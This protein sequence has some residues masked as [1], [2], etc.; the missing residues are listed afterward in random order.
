MEKYL[1]L[2]INDERI[3]NDDLLIDL[4]EI[5]QGSRSKYNYQYLNEIKL[6]TFYKNKE[7]LSRNLKRLEEDIEENIQSIRMVQLD[8]HSPKINGR[9]FSESKV[10]KNIAIVVCLK[11]TIY[12]YNEIVFFCDIERKDDNYNIQ[13][14]FKINR[15]EFLNQNKNTNWESEKQNNVNLKLSNDRQ[16][17]LTKIPDIKILI[18]EAEAVFEKDDY[19]EDKLQI[20]KWF[21][22]IKIMSKIYENDGDKRINQIVIFSKKKYLLS[23]YE[24]RKSKSDVL[25]IT[26]QGETIKIHQIKNL[27]SVK[28]NDIINKI[29]KENDEKISKLKE[30][31]ENLKNTINSYKKI[32]IEDENK[33]KE[34]NLE[35][36]SLEDHLSQIQSDLDLFKLKNSKDK[37][38]S[39]ELENNITKL[40]AEIKEQNSL[41]QDLKSKIQDLL[42]VIDNNKSKIKKSDNDAN[43][44]KKII[45]KIEKKQEHISHFKN[46]I[47][48]NEYKYFYQFDQIEL[49]K[50]DLKDKD[51]DLQNWDK[52]ISEA[53]ETNEIEEISVA[54]KD[55]ATYKKI[56]RMRFALKRLNSGYYKN[57]YLYKA[58]KTPT[59][60]SDFNLIPQNVKS[61][62]RLNEKQEKA[63]KKAINT[64]DI[65][66]LQGPP[67]T[68]K[69][70]TLCAISESILQNNKNLV[71]CSSTHEAISNFLEKLTDYNKD[72][73]NL[74]IF[75]YRFGKSK[76]D[77]FYSEEKLFSN[78]KSAIYEFVLPQSNKSSLKDLI[79]NYKEKYNTLKAPDF[80]SKSLFKSFVNVIRKNY[81]EFNNK[82]ELVEI[83]WKEDEYLRPFHSTIYEKGNL[84]KDNVNDISIENAINSLYNWIADKKNT[85]NYQQIKDFDEIVDSFDFQKEDLHYLNDNILEY[86]NTKTKQN[87]LTD[88]QIRVKEARK[89]FNQ[90]NDQKEQIF[91]KHIFSNN[92]INVIG[93]TTTSRQSIEIANETKNL[94]SD[95][96]VD[97][98]LIDEISKSS[99]PEILTK[100][101]LAK[102]IILSGDYLQLPPSPEFNSEYDVNKIINYL[103]NNGS[104]KSNKKDLLHEQWISLIQSYENSDEANENNK[105]ELIRKIQDEISQLFKTSFFVTQIEKIKNKN[106]DITKRSF[107]FLQE[108]RR[109][110][111]DILRA[112]NLIYPDNEKLI[113]VNKT[114]KKFELKIRNK[115]LDNEFV[116]VDTSKIDWNHFE[117]YHE[118]DKKNLFDNNRVQTFDQKGNPFQI[119]NS[120]NIQLDNSSIYNQYS[121][122]VIINLAKKLLEQNL[123]QINGQNRIAIITL[124]KNQKALVN[125]Y[126]KIFFDDSYYNKHKRSIKVDTIDNFQGREEEIV[127]V[128]FIR[129]ETKIE[130]SK[131][132]QSLKRRNL[133]FLEEKE[134]INVALSRAKSKLILI[135][136]FKHYLSG[137]S[138]KLFKQYLDI[139]ENKDN[140]YLLYE[141][142]EE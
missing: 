4:S 67:G 20:N 122:L 15:I 119:K 140:A 65:F 103:S 17:K 36:N 37:H 92:L 10:I 141:K 106:L 57:Y 125:Q 142:I 81:E 91:L 50:K 8:K 64:N 87:N 3:R 96:P 35:L 58:I 107:E 85:Y 104:N 34:F 54:S 51:D 14:L 49:D 124:T 42:R 120:Q 89:H 129:G 84:T 63:V 88:F 12:Q 25:D 60:I 41:K 97:T 2:N 11:E 70:H 86:L 33:I 40:K 5:P 112:V 44:N 46:F 121:A 29:E 132:Y 6:Q 133:S 26:S 56:R 7:S 52:F 38:L 23:Q 75:K 138:N 78:F 13:C 127:I 19:E 93:I 99:T 114:I 55:S 108:S 27:E 30:E 80:A 136:S 130:N 102:K 90:I 28:I 82:E 95:Y 110:S 48:K 116:I 71:M 98:I 61:K 139:V 47:E 118:I 24:Y 9:K 79:D 123:N 111:G 128:D 94:F 22:F 66:Y 72:N 16:K 83:V 21:N 31:N 1:Y 76:K 69:T 137:L 77:Q 32:V 101:V 59:Q 131:I 113:S 73:P 117:K 100:I 134:R 126:L 68:G 43:N 135:G 105:N 115:I 109:F 39:K 62:Y 53:L 74:I 18:D 45:S